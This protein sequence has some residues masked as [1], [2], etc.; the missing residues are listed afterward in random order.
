MDQKTYHSKTVGRCLTEYKHKSHNE[1]CGKA[2]A[3]LTMSQFSPKPEFGHID[4]KYYHDGTVSCRDGEIC[5]AL[6]EN[7]F[8]MIFAIIDSSD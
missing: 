2:T 6:V 3:F 7:C 4:P 1:I 8:I 5:Y